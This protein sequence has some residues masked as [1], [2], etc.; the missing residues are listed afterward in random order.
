MGGFSTSQTGA[1]TAQKI[2]PA[3]A[4]SNH[5]LVCSDLVKV[6]ELHRKF[7]WQPPDEPGNPRGAMVGWDGGKFHLE[8]LIFDVFWLVVS[9]MWFQTCGFKHVVSNTWFFPQYMG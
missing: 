3:G 6:D 5:P 8:D 7:S 9:N 2:L 4:Q 1:E